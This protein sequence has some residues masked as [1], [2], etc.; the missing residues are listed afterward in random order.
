MVAQLQRLKG[1]LGAL[2]SAASEATAAVDALS[3]AL[4]GGGV[5]PSRNLPP[6]SPTGAYFGVLSGLPLGLPVTGGTCPCPCQFFTQGSGAQLQ[7][8]SEGGGARAAEGLGSQNELAVRL[9]QAF[10]QA[11]VEGLGRPPEVSR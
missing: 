8:S 7:A 11:R 10:V 5:P 3:V 6:M 9:Q 4:Q 2:S 1:A